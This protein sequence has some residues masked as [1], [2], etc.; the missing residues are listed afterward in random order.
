MV[1]VPAAIHTAE[2]KSMSGL[3]TRALSH[4]T[5]GVLEDGVGFL[6]TLAA[7]KPIAI[8]QTDREVF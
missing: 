7:R 5:K 4:P 3:L 8:K 1:R 2:R 6:A